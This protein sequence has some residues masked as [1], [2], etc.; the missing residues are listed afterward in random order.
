M[1]KRTLAAVLLAAV[2]APATA[3]AHDEPHPLVIGH[4]GA[5]GYLPDHTLPGYP[6]AAPPGEPPPLSSAPGAGGAS[7]PTHPRPGSARP[8]K[9]GA[10]YTARARLP[11]RAGQLTPRHEPNTPPPTT[12]AAPPG[13][14]ARKRT[15]VID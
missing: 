3:A 14:A 7:G 10:D 2:L 8:T 11:T 6:P 1:L 13:F 4:R 12:V 15:A 5:G 9:G